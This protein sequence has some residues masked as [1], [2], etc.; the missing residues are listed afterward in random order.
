MKKLTALL[1]VFSVAFTATA[2]LSST[3]VT[4]N[5]LSQT[6]LKL[7]LPIDDDVTEDFFMDGLK[8]AGYN[9]SKSK[10]FTKSNRIDEGFYAI[11]GVRLQGTREP[12]DLYVKMEQKGKKSNHES[13]I[14]LL[15]SKEGGF[16]TT[17]SDKTT[18]SAS[19]SF[20]TS[21]IDQ[22]AAYKLKKAI[23]EQEEVLKD[24]EKKL[25][26][27]Q[28]DEKDLEKR[29]QNLQEDLKENKQDQKEQENTIEKEKKKLEDLKNQAKKYS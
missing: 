19:E 1:F 12:V 29:I 22:A 2:Q 23:E 20:L 14:Y 13:T 28:K 26:R 5:K 4:L 3:T 7:D 15:V 10:T 25:D 6:A 16:I 8:K 17:S 18:Y 21:F 24:A 11:K 27:Q 9:E